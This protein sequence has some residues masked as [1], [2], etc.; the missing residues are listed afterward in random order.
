MSQNVILAGNTLLTLE[1]KF[2]TTTKNGT[3][4]PKYEFLHI[5]S[6]HKDYNVRA[7]GLHPTKQ[8]RPHATA[9]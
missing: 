1:M 3:K 6:E 8:E 5:N 2:V 9:N 4:I 7:C